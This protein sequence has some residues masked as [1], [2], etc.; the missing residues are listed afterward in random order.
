[1]LNLHQNQFLMFALDQM[2]NDLENKGQEVIRMTLGKSDLPLHDNIV[3]AMVNVL[4]DPKR[5]DYVFPSGVPEFKEELANFY[6]KKY[7][8]E[9]LPNNFIVSPGTSTTLRNLLQ[10]LLKAGDECLLPKPYYCLYLMSCIILPGVKVKYYDI[11][12]DTMSINFDSFRKNF[13]DRTKVVIIN[14]PGNPLGNIITRDQLKLLD[15][16][17]NKNATIISDEIYE[18]VCFEKQ[19]PSII[20]IDC[21]S[22]YIVMN[23]CSKAYRMYA[24]RV[25]WCL[26]PNNTELLNNMTIL[27]EHTMLTTDPVVQYGAI[28]ALR[29]QS[30][31]KEICDLYKQRNIYT[32]ERLSNIEN[33][34]VI[35][36]QGSF[37]ITLD[38][39]NYLEKAGENSSYRLAK[40]IFNNT[41]VA[42]VPGSDF[43]IPLT[44]RLS[45]TAKQYNQG[46]DKIYEYFKK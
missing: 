27:Q 45:Y 35:P 40:D 10:L 34:K 12:L 9:F 3:F 36:A 41:N 11:D 43:G 14:S 25:G 5:R 19:S 23:S 7:K 15:S 30:E 18:N 13:T 22:D 16:I 33:I 8:K 28:E 37:Y 38:C 44:L 1:M 4:K 46:I 24:R 20:D 17:V 26:I 31:V 39:R 21:K 42:T 32:L 29:M 6:N 2:A